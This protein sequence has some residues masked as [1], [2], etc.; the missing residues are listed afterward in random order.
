MI[1]GEITQQQAVYD[2]RGSA[3]VDLVPLSTRPKS[4]LHLRLAVLDNTKWNAG[5]LL[6]KT[7]SKLDEEFSFESINYYKKESFSK[8]ASAP[9]LAE[10]AEH[11]DIA[12]TAIGD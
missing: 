2:P 5:K 12:I 10:I 8:V 11:N 9:L 4:L 6:R 1:S 7:M 3:E